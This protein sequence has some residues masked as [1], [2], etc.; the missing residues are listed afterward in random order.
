MFCSIARTIRVT[1]R[2]RL[3]QANISLNQAGEQAASTQLMIWNC[4][5]VMSD[6]RTS[7]VSLKWA[8]EKWPSGP[9][10]TVDADMVL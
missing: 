8:L 7:H 1:S 6:V 5:C 2:P 10:W 9:G 4:D 3:L